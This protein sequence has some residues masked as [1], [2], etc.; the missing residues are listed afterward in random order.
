MNPMEDYIA[1]LRSA[2]EGLK[3]AAVGIK[4]LAP[5]LE[6][7]AKELKGA[8]ADYMRGATRIEAAIRRLEKAMQDDDDSEP[9]KR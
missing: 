5:E 2:A 7:M 4:K 3:E 1:G 8:G 9:W 6:R